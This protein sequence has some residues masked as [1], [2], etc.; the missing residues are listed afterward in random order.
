MKIYELIKELNKRRL[1]KDN[2]V[3]EV[4]KYYISMYRAYMVYLYDKGYISD[5][6]TFSYKEILGNIADM[7]IASLIGSEGKVELSEEYIKFSIAKNKNNPEVLDF[8]KTLYFVIKYRNISINIDKFYDALNLSYEYRVSTSM[9]IFQSASRIFTKNSYRLDEGVL[10]CFLKPNEGVKF[11]SLDDEIYRTALSE[12]GIEDTSKESLFVKGLTRDEESRFSRLILNGLV[13]LD[14]P[15]S[16]KLISWLRENKWSF[17]NR[18]FTSRS[19]GLYNYILYIKS[20]IMIDKQSELLNKLLSNGEVII[21]MESNGFFILSEKKETKVPMGIFVVVSSDEDEYLLPR[22]NIM[23]GYTGEV[24]S[25]SYLNTHNLNYVGC[26]LELYTSNRD[27]DKDFFIDREQT[28][29]VDG[30][31]WFEESGANIVFGDTLYKPGIFSEGSLEDEYFKLVGESETGKLI[32]TMGV[33]SNQK[34]LNK[35]KREV[36][37]KWEE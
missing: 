26:P 6:T 28:E 33:V 29:F 25:L 11:I 17:D 27:K 9:G 3:L 15:M 19:E 8:L 2:R 22:R 30:V 34:E 14:G 37:N 1:V 31:S 18:K 12:L 21:S 10:K 7:N 36:L 35:I 23:E 16:D 4:K 13:R 20:S 5:P 32:G 24:Y